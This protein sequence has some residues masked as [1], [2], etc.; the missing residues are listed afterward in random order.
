MKALNVITVLPLVTS[1]SVRCKA[2]SVA[3]IAWD[4]GGLNPLS[5]RRCCPA[6]GRGTRRGCAA[7]R[8][9]IAELIMTKHGVREA[10]SAAPQCGCASAAG[11]VL[12]GTYPAARMS[13]GQAARPPLG[14]CEQLPPPPARPPA[15]LPAHVPGPPWARPAPP[16]RAQPGTAPLSTAQ[17]GTARHGPAQPRAIRP[18]PAPLPCPPGGSE[19]SGA[20]P[21]L[22]ARASYA[23]PPGR[24]SPRARGPR[25]LP[26]SAAG[27][28]GLT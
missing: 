21:A 19:R 3:A 18:P 5:T 12:P 11:A 6:Q 17:P 20:T 27:P 1:S 14:G 22:P 13:Q 26:R 10:A 7:P 9:S 24:G 4:E 15:A 2:F 8:D 23:A 16:R 28:P 25:P